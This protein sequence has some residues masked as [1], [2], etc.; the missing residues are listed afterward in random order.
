M[1]RKSA[2]SLRP[3]AT[4]REQVEPVI[5]DVPDVVDADAKEAETKLWHQLRTKFDE[6]QTVAGLTWDN[7]HTTLRTVLAS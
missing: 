1:G 2:L 3:A 4:G 6:F 5:I 7:P